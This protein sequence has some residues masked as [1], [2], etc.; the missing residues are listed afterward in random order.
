MP[1]AAFTCPDDSETAATS[2]GRQPVSYIGCDAVTAASM[3]GLSAMDMSDEEA[4][5][6]RET[7]TRND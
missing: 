6:G 1:T 3:V 2:E 7:G 5:D 4:A